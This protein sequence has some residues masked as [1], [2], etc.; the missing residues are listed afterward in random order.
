[1][2]TASILRSVVN[3]SQSVANLLANPALFNTTTA[4]NLLIAVE[5][6]RGQVRELP[7]RFAAKAD[8]LG[9]LDQ[10]TAI[11]NSAI[12]AGFISATQLNSILELLQLVLFKVK[13][14]SC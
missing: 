11:I 8:I 3:L 10:I 7:L 14:F 9:R 4:T 1:M 13:S 12:A 2:S 5:L 6:I